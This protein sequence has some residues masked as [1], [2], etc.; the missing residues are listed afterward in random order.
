MS[1]KLRV[2]HNTEYR[3][4]RPVT[5][6]RHRLMLRPRDGHDLRVDDAFLTIHPAASLRWFFDAFGNS[7]AEAVFS[8]P[9]DRLTVR[10][11]L[12]LR[13]YAS[14]RQPVPPLTLTRLPIQYDDEDL[15][16]LQPF[17][18]LQNE[19]DRAVVQD[20]LATHVPND[21]DIALDRLQRISDTI[22]RVITYS[23]REA[24]GTQSARETIEQGKGTC[25]DYALLFMECARILGLAARFV[26]GYLSDVSASGQ[27]QVGTGATHAWA[28]IFIPGEGWTE[29]DPTN[30]IIGGSSLIRVATTRTPAE[31]KPVSGSYVG[32]ADFLGLNVSVQVHE[33]D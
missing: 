19:G 25:R 27:Q 20:W 7:V 12:L 32:Q 16:V 21:T 5:F 30:R 10:S 11:E 29:I 31:A 23:V 9:S 33:I 4:D 28:E 2:V 1:R 14:M 26:T 3:Y 24:M 8:E 6:Q 15:I 22:N 17:M 18:R 13:R